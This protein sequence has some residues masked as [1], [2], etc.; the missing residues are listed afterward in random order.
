VSKHRDRKCESC[1]EKIKHFTG[2]INCEEESALKTKIKK[3]MNE[4][5][6]SKLH[7]RYNDEVMS[8]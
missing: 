1:N 4:S 3:N 5:K 2:C 6:K 8:Q 7:S